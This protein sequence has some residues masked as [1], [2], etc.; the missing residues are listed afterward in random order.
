MASSKSENSFLEQLINSRNRDLSILF[1]LILGIMG[2]GGGGAATTANEG[3]EVDNVA[4]YRETTNRI[5]FINPFT[6]GA[7]VLEAGAGAGRSLEALLRELAESGNKGHPPTTTPT[8]PRLASKG[9]ID[10]MPRVRVEVAEECSICLK[11]M[12]REAME[13]PCKHRFLIAYRCGWASWVSPCLKVQ[14]AFRGGR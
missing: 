13:M 14:D 9:S 4:N 11:E 1:P 6:Q 3:E 2:G 7:I 5:I 10:E 12:V 8:T